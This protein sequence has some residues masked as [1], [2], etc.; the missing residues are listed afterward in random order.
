M[1]AGSGYSFSEL[2]FGW[3]CG[4]SPMTELELTAILFLYLNPFHPD[5]KTVFSLVLAA[6][7]FICQF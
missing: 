7:R 2:I 1:M 3:D 5:C 4:M 6:F